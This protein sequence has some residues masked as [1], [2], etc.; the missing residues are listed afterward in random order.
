MERELKE[1]MGFHLDME[2][3]KLMKAGLTPEA[4]RRQALR[5]F[6]EPLR[7]QEKARDSWGV[8]WVHDLRSDLRLT[9]R[10]S[11]KNPVLSI[12]AIVTLALGIGGATA[13]FTVVNGVLLKPLPYPDSQD[14]V[15]LN[16]TMPGIEAP[17]TPIGPALFFTYEE[18]ARSLAGIGLWQGLTRTVTGLAEPERVEAMSVT[19]GLLPVLGLHPVL[20]RGFT[21]DD[22]HSDGFNPVILSDA[23]WRT[24]FGADPNIL[25]RSIRVDGEER[26]IVGILPPGTR[27]QDR[28]PDLILPLRFDRETVGVGNWSF[29]GIARLKPGVTPDQATAELSQLTPLA[30]ELYPGIP[31]EEL[32]RRGFRTIATPL[33]QAMVG[34][35]TSVLWVLF[36]AVALVLLI[37]G[38]NVANLLLVK[39]ESGARDV[40]LRKAL[41]ASTER[42]TRQA[43]TDSLFLGSLGGGVGVFLAYAGVR[44]FLRM[45]PPSL[46]RIDEIGL[47]PV[48]IIF[49][50]SVTLLTGMTF[51]LVSAFRVQ[52]SSLASPLQEGSCGAGDGRGRI[53]AR[54][55]FA[56]TQISLALVLLVGSGLMVR[57][58]LALRSVPPGYQRPEEVVTFRISIP[59]TE[60]AVGEEVARAHREILRRIAEIP[61]VSS[62][63]AAASVAMEPWQ[64]WED[65][66]MEDFPIAEG[67]PNPLRRLNWI[68]PGHFETL[69][70]PLKV[71]RSFEWVDVLERRHVAVVS[72]TFAREFWPDPKEAIGKRFRMADYQPWK[73]IIGVAGDVRT[74]GVREDPPSIV[75]FPFAMEGLWG[76][77]V[78]TQRSLRYVVRTSRHPATDVLP[79]ARRAVG[80]VN[81]DLP[82]SSISTLDQIFARSIAQTSFAMTLL[83]MAAALAVLLGMVGV[84][85][86]ISFLVSQ[87]TREMGIRLAMGATPSQVRRMVLKK[88]GLLASVGVA[89]GIGIALALSQLMAS[90]LFGVRGSDPMTYGIVSISLTGV[91]LLASYLPARRAAGVGPTEALRRD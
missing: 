19:E 70:N 2:V 22:T 82:L 81:P 30:C 28:A 37:A 59:R 20:G 32:E 90:L 50:L 47:A 5:D 17:S 14:L 41:G 3:R 58:F 46:P 91:V 4:A 24:R 12:A 39:A 35:A 48:V 78:F 29:S 13:I 77:G 23:Y 55:V 31:L 6:G 40:A 54:N 86:V 66:F 74:R 64:A 51:G 26:P 84:Y 11:L 16:H 42:L 80:S 52:R 75:Y 33:K 63:S 89:L 45:A 18:H 68:T 53:R 62:A 7:Q 71:G 49:A 36:G 15:A 83:G 8:R 10:T 76:S 79:E 56:T 67:D 85:G 1:E 60:A 43:I 88:A 72:E 61:G 44:A 9:L 57:T 73:E 65:L 34:D 38:T 69:Q 25:D 87:R 27:I 21:R